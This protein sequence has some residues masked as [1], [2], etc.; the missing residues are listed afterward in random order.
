[1]RPDSLFVIMMAVYFFLTNMAFLSTCNAEGTTSAI[2]ANQIQMIRSEDVKNKVETAK[3][4]FNSN[5]YD[6]ALFAAINQELLKGYQLNPKDGDHVQAMAWLCKALATSGDDRYRAT[7]KEISQSAV[8]KKLRKYGERSIDILHEYIIRKADRPGLPEYLSPEV[9]E[10]V[11]R[12]TSGNDEWVVKAASEIFKSDITDEFLYETIAGVLLTA[13]KSENGDSDFIDAVSWLC[14]ALASSGIMKYKETLEEVAANAN[15]KK[16]RKF[17]KWSLDK[18][19][20]FEPAPAPK[21]DESIIVVYRWSFQLGLVSADILLD[22]KKA[23]EL[24]NKSYSW[25]R[26]APGKHVLEAKWPDRLNTITAPTLLHLEPG[27]TFYLKLE[28][29]VDVYLGGKKLNSAGEMVKEAIKV[30]VI[31]TTEAYVPGTKAVREASVKNA[32][33]AYHAENPKSVDHEISENLDGGQSNSFAQSFS[34]TVIADPE[35][36]AGLKGAVIGAGADIQGTNSS[37][38]IPP[39]ENMPSLISRYKYIKSKFD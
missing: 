16:V 9:G 5:N 30:S 37:V 19:L 26:V 10:Y 2:V 32:A 13:Y 12:V 29:N 20:L 27:K 15:K 1:M 36:P 17:A 33:D 25:M 3:K 4:I 8:N 31:G 34:D 7:L 24:K 39:T 28:P 38:F 11:N 21:L 23:V 6:Q 18:V 22:G 14:K 35:A